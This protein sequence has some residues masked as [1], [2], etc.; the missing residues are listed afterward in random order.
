MQ[1]IRV[2]AGCTRAINLRKVI[3]VHH[4]QRFREEKRMKYILAFGLG[5]PGVLV[6]AWFM[7]NHL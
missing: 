2:V 6:F 1:R 7:M 4:L 3:A 5:V